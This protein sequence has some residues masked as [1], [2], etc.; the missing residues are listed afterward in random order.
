MADDAIGD[1]VGIMLKHYAPWINE[2]ELTHKE[3]QREIVE[4]QA[5]KLAQ[6]EA[7]QKVV[8]IEAVCK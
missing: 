3:A 6:K 2:L 5:A 7:A 1:T 4:A 8:N